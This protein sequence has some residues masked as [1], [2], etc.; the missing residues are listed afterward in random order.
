MRA[1]KPSISGLMWFILFF[2]IALTLVRAEQEDAGLRHLWP[3]LLIGPIAGMWLWFVFIPQKSLRLVGRDPDR[4]RRLLECIVNTRCPPELKIHA[5]FILAASYQVA[6]DHA[7]CESLCRAILKDN[8]ST[9]DPGFESMVRQQLANAIDA[10]GRNAEAVAERERA[11]TILVGA[12]TSVLKHQAQGKLFDSEHKYDKAVAAYHAAL[13]VHPPPNK[14]VSTSLMLQLVNSATRAGRPLTAVRWAE[15]AIKLDPAGLHSDGARRMA[16]LAHSKLGQFD[17][18]ERHIRTALERASSPTTRAVTLAELALL[19][20]RR[21]ELDHAEQ[22]AREAEAIIPETQ[23]LP[24]KI[25]GKVE[26]ARGRLEAAIQAYEHAN[27]ISLS[28]IPAQN[29]RLTALTHRELAILH[30][31]LGQG[32][33]ALAL[34]SDAE[35]VLAGDPKQDVL[36]AAAAAFVHASRHEHDLALARIDAAQSGRA[37][38]DEDRSA[39]QSVLILLAQAALLIDEP[40][41]AESFL[42]EVVDLGPDPISHACVYYLLAECRRRT[43]DVAASRELALK[44]TETQFGTALGTPGAGK[45]GQPRERGEGTQHR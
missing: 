23:R 12:N 28:H 3:C 33:T 14:L 42:N 34:V 17:D 4:Q 18:A 41:Q 44:A 35:S 32:E 36:I 45:P 39:L 29:R 16:A 25:I 27:T 37:S 1:R 20:I 19:G 43:G 8:A 11:A 26:K 21:G 2:A 10:L 30:A 9:I 24:W 6:R 31:E 5:R 38:F 15:A 13:S 7:R 40:G 22:L